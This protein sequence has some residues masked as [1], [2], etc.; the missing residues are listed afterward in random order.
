MKL[1]NLENAKTTK[2][3][4]RGYLTGILYLASS[5]E[6]GYQVCPMAKK[7]GCEAPCLD[8]AG[9]GKFAKTRASR[10]RKTRL[11]FENRPLFMEMLRKDLKALIRKAERE[12]L[13]PCVR[14]NGTSDLPWYAMIKESQIYHD[15]Y[16]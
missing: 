12:N 9:R 16:W 6:S 13:I 11:Y 7:A 10:I 2:G 14:L 5:D 15:G 1:I 8:F 4:K 3:D